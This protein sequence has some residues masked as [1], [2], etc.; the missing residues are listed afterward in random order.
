MKRIKWVG[1]KLS[2][3]EKKFIECQLRLMGISFEGKEL[4]DY[5]IP[6]PKSKQDRRLF[7]HHKYD[8]IY[9]AAVPLSL[10]PDWNRTSI[11]TIGW[12]EL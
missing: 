3:E 11:R 6:L 9:V 10:V 8:R 4:I 5:M 12:V 1:E 7:V 2:D